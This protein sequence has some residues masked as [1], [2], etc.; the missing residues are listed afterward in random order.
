MTA[1]L[2]AM[3]FGY[4]LPQPLGAGQDALGVLAAFDNG[5]EMA[6]RWPLSGMAE[7]QEDLANVRRLRPGSRVDAVVRT[8]YEAAVAALEAKVRLGERHSFAR[9]LDAS[10][11][12]RERLVQFWAD[13]FTVVAREVPTRI[14]TYTIVEDAI[15]PRLAETFEEMFVAAELHPAMLLYLDQI[16]SVGPNTN[17]GKRRGRGLNENLAREM[18]E[19]HSLGA[20]AGYSQQDVRQLAELLTGLTFSQIDG[21]RYDKNRAE[22]GPEQILG[23]EYT[24]ESL[25]TIH[26]ALRDL[27]RHSAT[28]A[29]VCRKLAVHFI[30]DTPDLDLLIQMEAAWGTAGGDLRAVYAAMLSHKAAWD[31]VAHKARQPFEFLVAA[32]RA[33]GVDGAAVVAM[34]ARD[35][36]RQILDPMLLMGQR[37]KRPIGPDG[38]AEEPQ[39]WITPQGLASRITWAMEVPGRLVKPLPEPGALAVRALGDRLTEAVRKAATRAESQREGVGLV[40]ASAEFNR[41]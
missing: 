33:L 37:M 4:G 9:A 1:T 39:A 35:F 19:L 16:N 26:L 34:T 12:F 15:R 36:Q 8:Q 17:F 31:P 14:M 41:R 22:P 7:V 30:S 13:H 20:D 6:V 29:H 18:I 40:L 25:D 28:R 32:L 21:L 27:A 3:R 10:D 23:R 11:G 38:W 24:G 5:D 2:A